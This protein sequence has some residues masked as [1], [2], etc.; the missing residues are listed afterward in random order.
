MRMALE[1]QRKISKEENDLDF[2]V[3]E[4]RKGSKRD[5]LQLELSCTYDL[6]YV[7]HR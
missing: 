3:D 4:E 2:V 1:K 7:W 5:F 6:V